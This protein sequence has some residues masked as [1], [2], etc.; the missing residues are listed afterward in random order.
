MQPH[1]P[2]PIDAKDVPTPKAP[3]SQGI[4]AGTQVFVSGQLGIDPF[5]GEI[6]GS[7]ADETRHAMDYMRAVLAAAGLSMN[8]VC[9]TTI[10]MI[11]FDDYSKVNEVYSKYFETPPAR[12]TVKVAELTMGARVEIEA[13]AVRTS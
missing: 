11:D 5:T 10:F 9:K 7:V 8:E 6:P 3:Y 4:D 2:I 1:A 13:I 12:S